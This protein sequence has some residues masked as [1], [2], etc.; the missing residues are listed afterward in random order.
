[1]CESRKINDVIVGEQ[2]VRKQE[3]VANATSPPDVGSDQPASTRETRSEKVQPTKPSLQEVLVDTTGL[4][5]ERHAVDSGTSISPN[6]NDHEEPTVRENEEVPFNPDIEWL[7]D[8]SMDETIPTLLSATIDCNPEP[9][10]A[11]FQSSPNKRQRPSRNAY[12]PSRFR[13]SN[14]ETQFQPVLRR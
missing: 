4:E 6:V 10:N 13:D 1:M 11:I 3:D 14:F 7:E 12:R 5:P 8:V 9:G 2:E